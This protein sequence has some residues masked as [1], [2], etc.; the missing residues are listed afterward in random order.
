MSVFTLLAGALGLMPLP[1]PVPVRQLRLERAVVVADQQRR[2][3][4]DDIRALAKL[5]DDLNEVF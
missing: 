5:D 2:D 4:L 1:L 3:L